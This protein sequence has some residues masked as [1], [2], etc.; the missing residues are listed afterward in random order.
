MSDETKVTVSEF[1]NWLSGVLDFQPDDW[2]PNAEQWEKIHNKINQLDD[3]LIQV[4]APRVDTGR[5]NQSATRHPRPAGPAVPGMDGPAV[6]LPEP[7]PKE[8]HVNVKQTSPP[9]IITGEDGT[10]RVLDTGKVHEMGVIDTREKDY[11]SSFV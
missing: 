10:E 5:P 2:V 8:K 6:Q 4:K 9:K 7:P 11:E 3:E 1:K